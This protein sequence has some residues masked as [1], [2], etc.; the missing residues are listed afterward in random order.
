MALLR[1]VARTP[2]NIDT[3]GVAVIGLG[4][5]RIRRVPCL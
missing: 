4:A 1:V 5:N 3:G 2:H